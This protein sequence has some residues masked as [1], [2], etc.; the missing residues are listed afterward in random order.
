MVATIPAIPLISSGG[1]K[2]TVMAAANANIRAAFHQ[3]NWPLA[4]C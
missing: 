1:I 3:K 2:S 4:G